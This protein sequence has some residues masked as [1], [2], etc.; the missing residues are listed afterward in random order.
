VIEILPMEGLE[1]PARHDD[2]GGA[3]EWRSAA[4]SAQTLQAGRRIREEATMS[5]SP[6]ETT[7]DAWLAHPSGEPVI[8]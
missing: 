3:P 2:R 1:R 7:V 8:A 5:D 6:V 4:R